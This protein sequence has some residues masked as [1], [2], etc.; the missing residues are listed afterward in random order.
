M[1]EEFKLHDNTILLMKSMDKE[2]EISMWLVLLR[3][4]WSLLNS[5]FVSNLLVCDLL[6][7]MVVLV[8]NE[9]SGKNMLVLLRKHSMYYF[10]QS[11]YLAS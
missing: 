8:Q 2:A 6:S 4:R 9:D 11:V 7:S 1:I 3:V 5:A 10:N